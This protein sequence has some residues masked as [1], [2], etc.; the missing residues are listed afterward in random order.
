M[1][2]RKLQKGITLIE[3][4]V[5]IAI[6]IILTA[7]VFNFIYMIYRAQGYSFD[8][9]QA[10]NEARKGVEAMVKE[11]REAQAAQNGAY[12]IITTNDLEFS[13]YGDIDKDS[14]IEKVRYFIDGTNFKKAIIEPTA[15]S[16]LGDLPARYLPEN[17]QIS[18]LSQYVRNSAPIFRYFDGSGNELSAVNRKKNTK[19]MRLYLIINVNPDRPPNDFYLESETQI[20]NLKSNL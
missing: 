16:Q 15:V 14:S 11:I 2:E 13:F 6:F 12:I 9:A 3:S 17:E 1:L 4:L 8:Q 20:R 18:I 19:I 5:S 10:I 7:V